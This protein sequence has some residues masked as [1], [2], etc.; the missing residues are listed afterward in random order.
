MLDADSALWSHANTRILDETP[1]KT[2]RISI[3][4][5]HSPEN[6]APSSGETADTPRQSHTSALKTPR[7]A[8][9][10]SSGEYDVQEHPA[11]AACQQ[12]ALCIECLASLQKP[13]PAT[14]NS[15][16][17]PHPCSTTATQPGPQHAFSAAIA[18]QILHT[19]GRQQPGGTAMQ[20]VWSS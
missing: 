14:S 20:S 11:L 15:F 13:K 4:Q 1:P 16:M 7:G 2:D 17:S 5:H 10:D 18:K 12:H 3:E 8:E 6:G 19:I 9:H